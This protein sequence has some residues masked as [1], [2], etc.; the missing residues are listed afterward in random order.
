MHLLPPIWGLG[1][2]VSE[3]DVE[4]WYDKALETVMEDTQIKG[5]YAGSGVDEEW[6]LGVLKLRLVR[7]KFFREVKEDFKR[8]SKELY[9]ALGVPVK[10]GVAVRERVEAAVRLAR[11]LEWEG[12]LKLAMDVLRGAVGIAFPGIRD[13]ER[14]GV[15]PLPPMLNSKLPVMGSIDNTP[16]LMDA[17]SELGM[18]FARHEEELVG[19]ELLTEVLMRRKKGPSVSDPMEPSAAEKI[20]D[21][22]KV[23]SS[24]AGVGELMFAIGKKMDGLAWEEKAFMESRPL[25]EFRKACKECAGVSASNLIQMGNLLIE[26]HDNA[27]EKAKGWFWQKEKDS[28]NSFTKKDAE[29]LV[30]IYKSELNDIMAIRAVKDDPE[31]TKKG[32]FD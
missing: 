16:E 15:V 30:A 11:V 1:G 31:P 29:M 24:M 20:S 13:K 3:D 10:D 32:R 14:G 4:M 12:Q 19:L 7:A 27:E 6:K 22:C 17:L 26:E 5:G 2:D 9:E 21:P 8:E 23:A 28:E 18:F 25:A